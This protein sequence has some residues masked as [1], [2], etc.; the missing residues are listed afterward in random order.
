MNNYGPGAPARPCIIA[1]T[2]AHSTLFISSPKPWS[3]HPVWSFVE[4][5][6]WQSTPLVRTRLP[7]TCTPDAP[8]RC[9]RPGCGRLAVGAS[10][11]A[12]AA[13]GAL[14]TLHAREGRVDVQ[15]LTD[16]LVELSK[17][18]HTRIRSGQSV[19]ACRLACLFLSGIFGLR[20]GVRASRGFSAG[21]VDALIAGHERC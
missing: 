9:E 14:C 11:S 3:I 15:G 1:E 5:T 20:L 17:A 8:A 6:R 16:V 13:G 12:S 19:L 2:M 7:S 18:R 21:V 4:T 10:T